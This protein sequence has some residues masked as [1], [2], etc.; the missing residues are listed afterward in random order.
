MSESTATAPAPPPIS[1]AA[2]TAAL[3]KEITAEARASGRS[4]VN[5]PDAPSD[6]GEAP[7][8]GAK[9]KRGNSAPANEDLTDDAET[10][11][12]NREENEAED[13]DSSASDASTSG[14]IDAQA[15]QAALKADGGVDMLALAKALGVDPTKLRVTPSAAAAL[16]I[17]KRKADVMIK[18]AEDIGRKLNQQ[19]GD[20]VAARKAAAAGE[21]EPAIQFI[22][23]TFGMGWN[24]LNKMVAD[25]LQG[26]PPKDL[27]QK[28]ELRDLKKREAE[29]QEGERKAAADRAQAAKTEEAK[30]WIASSLKGDK[31]ATPE[32]NKQLAEAGFPSITDL[33]FE[34][35]RAH[36]SSGLT[37]PKKA[38][39]RVKL[40]LTKQARAL[41]TAGLLPKTAGTTPA[42]KTTN[43]R[44]RAGAQTG[45]A[46]NGR[47]MTDRELREA[48]LKE[49]GLWR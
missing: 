39:E 27:E 4:I 2:Q 34:E 11:D 26:K 14:E 10:S 32:L 31:L 45:A 38:L 20:Q 22:E 37:D 16:R 19:Y 1:D 40:K 29:R 36:Y 41:Q 8:S 30:A 18:K 24:D 3:I 42:P 23:N 33:V 35:M 7:L 13:D 5:D 48:V 17:Q 28:R 12:Q 44:P 46:G 49:A 6:D 47:Q 9:T 25:L 21:L 15:V 43:A